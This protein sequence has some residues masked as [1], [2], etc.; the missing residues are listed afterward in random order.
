MPP[1]LQDFARLVEELLKISETVEGH[2]T[3]TEVRFL[4]LLAAWPTARGEILEVGSFKGKSTIVLAKAAAFAGEPKVVAVDPLTSP[5]STDPHLKGDA[6]GLKDSQANLKKAGVEWR[7][8]FHQTHSAELARVWDK[9]RKIRL[10]WLDGDHTYAGVKADFAL[11]SLSLSE[12]AIVAFHN[13]LN[14]FEGPIR[15]F[16]EE[17]LP[18]AHFSAG[19]VCGSIG[20]SQY[21]KGPVADGKRADEKASLRRRLSRLIPYTALDGK[22]GTL[23]KLKRKVIRARVPRSHVDPARWLAEIVFVE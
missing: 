18:S 15:V 14:E 8:E 7:V 5:S 2:L 17:V 9:T 16:A 19:S 6:S 23:A 12:G 10:L 20:W 1:D 11:F 13:V 4:A 21:C 3:P 22:P